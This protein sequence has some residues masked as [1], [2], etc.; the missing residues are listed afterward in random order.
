MR[1]LWASKNQSHFTEDAHAAVR[2]DGLEHQGHLSSRPLHFRVGYKREV[3]L[4]PS[5]L[6]GLLPSAAAYGP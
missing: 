1:G 6:R 5:K 3:C 4:W 2:G